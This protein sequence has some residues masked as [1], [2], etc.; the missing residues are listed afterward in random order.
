MDFD[1]TKV[2]ELALQDGS[3]NLTFEKQGT[4]W[5]I[6]KSSAPVADD[7]QFDES[8]VTARLNQIRNAKGVKLAEG[9]TSAKAGLSASKSKATV[10]LEDG[11]KVSLTFGAETKDENR[12]VVYASGTMDSGI[13]L[14][15]SWVKKNTLGGLETFKKEVDPSGLSNLDPK[16]LQGLPPDVRASLQQQMQ[17]K[18]KE[19]DLMQKVQAQLNKEGK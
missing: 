18:K 5:K 17:Q 4:A 1:T 10:T 16:S 7:F 6:G 9:V 3:L 11:K 12:D 8:K 2:K 14:L 15:T 19:Q 13:Y